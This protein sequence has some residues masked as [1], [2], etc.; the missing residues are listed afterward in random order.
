MTT[1]QRRRIA[2]ELTAELRQTLLKN[3]GRMPDTWDGRHVRAFA[4][5]ALRRFNNHPAVDK[6]EREIRRSDVL[7]SLSY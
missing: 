4:G 5:M 2:R 6:A 1:T 7:Y 3:C